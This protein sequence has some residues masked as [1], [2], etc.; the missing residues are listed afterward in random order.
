LAD[1]S[2]FPR[3][4]ASPRLG[5]HY[6]T[7]PPKRILFYGYPH[8]NKYHFVVTNR[9]QTLPARGRTGPTELCFSVTEAP[10]HAS[11]AGSCPASRGEGEKTQQPTPTEKPK[12]N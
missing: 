8:L 3:R 11:G 7:H 12:T 9:I 6:V 10:A 2:A 5:P 1:I 4:Q